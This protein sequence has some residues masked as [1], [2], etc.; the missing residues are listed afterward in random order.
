MF[1][2]IH[3]WP[4]LSFEVMPGTMKYGL[5][6]RRSLTAADGVGTHSS[7]SASPSQKYAVMPTRMP[8]HDC[9]PGPHAAAS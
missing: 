1:Q 7:P 6:E 5:T 8:G 2:K 9:L 3:T 4:L